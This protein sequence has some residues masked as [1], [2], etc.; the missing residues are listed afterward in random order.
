MG[1]AFIVIC[2]QNLLVN[3]IMITVDITLYS[4]ESFKERNYQKNQEKLQE[5]R[6]ENLIMISSQSSGMNHKITTSLRV[7]EQIKEMKEW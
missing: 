1:W 2:A 5:K 7:Q 6:V 3:I 4:F